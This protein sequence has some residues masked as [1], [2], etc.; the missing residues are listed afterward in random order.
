MAA[1]ETSA[2]PGRRITMA[3]TKPRNTAA[4][5]RAR[6]ISPSS[7]MATTVANSGAVK[8]RATASPRFI[9]EIA[10]NQVIMAISPTTP[11]MA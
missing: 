11:R 9:I 10:V 8:L 2:M 5:R 3:P 6:T 7:R 1:G 4:Q